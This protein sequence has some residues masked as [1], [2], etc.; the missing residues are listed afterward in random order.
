M[1]AT[2]KV[3]Q[4]LGNVVDVEFTPETLPKI[5]DALRVR[6]NE[7]SQGGGQRRGGG[8]HRA[9]RH[10]DAGARARA[11]SA[12][13][14]RQQ[15]GAL[16]RD[17]ARP[18]VSCA[19]PTC[20]RPAA[21]FGFRSAK[22]RSD[23]SSTC[24]A[25]RSIPTRRWMPP[26]HWPIHRPAPEFEVSGADGAHLRDRHQSRRLDGALHARRQGRPLR[27]RGRRQDGADSRADS[28]HRVRAQRLLG[29]HRRRRAH[30][31]RQR[32]LARDERIGRARA[33]DARLRADGRAARACVS[34]SRRP[35]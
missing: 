9:R 7:G 21:R 17:W 2:G 12:G 5:N 29:V 30:A 14:A 11:R 15:S 3:V 24:S 27:R 19:A 18:T 4:V 16:S 22:A 33:D 6:V 1:A 32:P 34:A 10:G 13:R 35:A 23:A 25:R 26:A 20:A 31:R 28:Q 8:G